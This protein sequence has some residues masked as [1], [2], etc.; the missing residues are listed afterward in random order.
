MTAL[1]RESCLLVIKIRHAVRAI[2]TIG[3]S[4]AEFIPVCV[5]KDLISFGM[6]GGA[7]RVDV[8]LTGGDGFMTGLACQGN[9]IIVILVVIEAVACDVMLE[10]HQCCF[11]R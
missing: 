9:S 6:T 2:V 1:Q 8:Y 7:F 5:H 3:A 11:S 10:I 4:I